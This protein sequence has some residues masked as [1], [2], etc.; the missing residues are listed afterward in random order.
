MA[1][2]FA[3]VMNLFGSEADYT[4][5]DPVIL[6]GEIAFADVNG[7]ILGK[8]GDGV[9]KWSELEYTLGTI[10]V[11]LAGTDPTMPVTGQITFD[12]LALGKEY[13]IGIEEGLSI[14][15]FVISASGGVNATSANIYVATNG[16]S[17]GFQADGLLIAPDIQYQTGDELALVNKQY[18]DDAVAGGVSGDFIP[19]TGNIGSGQPV[20]GRIEF[21]DSVL[22]LEYNLGIIEGFGF[23]CFVITGAGDNVVNCEIV[24]QSNSYLW[25]FEKNGRLFAPDVVYGPGDA[26][27]LANKQFVD[28]L[29]QDCIDAGVAISAPT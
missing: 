15:N 5:E 24:I 10:A 19:L 20:S 16:L 3:R 28:Q 2:I 25:K 13:T 27:A 9:K 8:V 29:R 4:T 7:A 26:L 14:D 6:L 22:D 21:Y 17:W 18:V 12:S 1:D 11:P 23:D